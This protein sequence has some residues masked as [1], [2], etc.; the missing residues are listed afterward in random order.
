MKTTIELPDDLAHEAEVKGALA[1]RSLKDMLTEGLRLLLSRG[2]TI[3][4]QRSGEG[5]SAQKLGG[6]AIADIT[7]WDRLR[8]AY[9][10][11]FP[12]LTTMQMLDEFRGPVELPPG[13]P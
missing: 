1:G 2:E 10:D 11:P 5:D 7:A 4:R 9:Q 6:A 13:R 3:S 8:A 12:G